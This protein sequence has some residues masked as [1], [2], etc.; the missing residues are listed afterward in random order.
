MKK[1]Y[2]FLVTTLLSYVHSYSQT[3]PT[4]ITTRI[5]SA[6]FIFEGEV[7]R[8]NGYWNDK[9]DYIYTSLTLDIKKYLKGLSLA[10]KSK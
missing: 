7:I 8:D 1:L 6:E 3:I 2:L 4:D 5:S 9:K 10:E